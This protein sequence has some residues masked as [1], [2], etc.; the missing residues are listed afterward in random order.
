[1]TCIRLWQKLLLWLQFVLSYIIHDTQ[2]GLLKDR[3]I[4]YNIFLFWEMVALAQQNKQQLAIFL[5][6]FEK[7]YDKVDWDFLEEMLWRLGFPNAWITGVSALY[8]Q[9]MKISNHWWNVGFLV[10][11]LG[12]PLVILNN[13][14]HISHYI[15]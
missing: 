10:L 7:A 11:I 2:F 1:M 3:S 6:D 14:T 5:L 15:V 8:R 12:Q 13:S 4:V 9:A